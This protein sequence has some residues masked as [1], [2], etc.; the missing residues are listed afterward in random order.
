[1]TAKINAVVSLICN[2]GEDLKGEKKGKETF[3]S[4]PSHSVI[5]LGFEPRTP[6]LKV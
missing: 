3:L 5:P 2:V 1:M 6:T 4:C